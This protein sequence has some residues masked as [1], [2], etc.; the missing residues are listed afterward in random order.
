MLAFTYVDG[1]TVKKYRK[2][3]ISRSLLLFFYE[4][5]SNGICID[6]LGRNLIRIYLLAYVPFAFG[7]SVGTRIGIYATVK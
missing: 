3:Y 6:C 1:D 4:H 5:K 2:W 7:I